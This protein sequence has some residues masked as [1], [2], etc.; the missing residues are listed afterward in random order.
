MA[1]ITLEEAK[2]EAV[3]R[4]NDRGPDHMNCAQAIVYFALLVLGRDPDYVTIARYLGG[5][6]AG[7]GEACGVLTGAALAMGLRDL[8]LDEEPEDLTSR[9]R[10]DLQQL[11]KDFAEESDALR[12]ADLTGCDLSTPEGRDEFV[13]TGANGRCPLYVGW[14]CDHVAPLLQRID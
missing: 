4:F 7:M 2:A 14:M 13:A 12:C 6:I 8:H 5:G 3:A 11:L 9:T 1:R 10:N